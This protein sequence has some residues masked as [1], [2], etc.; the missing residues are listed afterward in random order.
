MTGKK[1][2]TK[3]LDQFWKIDDEQINTPEHDQMLL[4]WL[5]KKENLRRIITSENHEAEK[6]G[7]GTCK[8]SCR[9]VYSFKQWI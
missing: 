4:S 2:R 7:L 3:S 5:L 6:M 9:G 8:N 1:T